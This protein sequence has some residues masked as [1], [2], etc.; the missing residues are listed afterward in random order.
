METKTETTP[1]E[2]FEKLEFAK[3]AVISMV[4]KPNVSVNFH[5]LTYWAG[6][7]ERIREEIKKML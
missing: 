3:N 6:E 1:Q 2:L 7:V 4:N 5:G